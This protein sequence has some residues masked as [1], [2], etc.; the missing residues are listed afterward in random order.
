MKRLVVLLTLALALSIFA[1]VGAI[2]LQ[3]E[4]DDRA[5]KSLGTEKVYIAQ[6]D[7]PTK[8]TLGGALESGA[9]ALKDF[10]S[11]LL[12]SDAIRAIPDNLLGQVSQVPIS[13][14]QILYLSGFAPEAIAAPTV[15]R[16]ALF[17]GMSAV[18]LEIPTQN[19][20]GGY[21]LPGD[22]VTVLSTAPEGNGRLSTRAILTD[23]KIL[24]IGAKSVKGLSVLDATNVSSD[25]VTLSV[26]PSL[27]ADLLTSAR[28]GTISLILTQTIG[29]G[30]RR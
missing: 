13:K 2:H 19:R 15:N 18:S 30:E 1:G 22:L 5:L 4:A 29:S 8:I 14:G 12:S 6:Y 24:A 25:L 9:I 17:A 10:P 16:S 27:V 7:L 26:T 23:V 28:A 21:L 11:K 3:N 20:V